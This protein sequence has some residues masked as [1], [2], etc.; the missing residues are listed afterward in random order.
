MSVKIVSIENPF[1]PE[2]RKISD[3]DFIPHRPLSHY[4]IF[5]DP[6]EFDYVIAVNGQIID[7][8]YLTFPKDGDI[9]SVCARL[10]D[11]ISATVATW[12][13]SFIAEGLLNTIVYGAVYGAVFLG[14]SFAIGY[15]MNQLINALG[16]IDEPDTSGVT[17]SPTYGWDILRPTMTEGNPIPIIFG[18]NKVAGQVINKFVT[19]STSEADEKQAAIEYL[20]ILLAICDATTRDA[21]GDL[22]WGIDSDGITDI[23]INDQPVTN[24]KDITT[25]T[26]AGTT[27]DALIPEFTEIVTHQSFDILIPFEETLPSDW[28]ATIQTDGTAVEKLQIILDAKR[29]LYHVKES[30]DPG[31]IKD[32]THTIQ[33]QYKAVGDSGWTDFG[34][35]QITGQGPTPIKKV[36]TIDS[37]SADQ[38][39][40]RMRITACSRVYNETKNTSDVWIV[41]LK[42]I[43][44]DAL[45]YPGVAKYAIK[46]LA[47][48]QLSGVMPSVSCLASRSIVRV[49]NDDT[50]TWVA[51]DA[52]NPAWAAYGLLNTHHGISADQIVWSEFEDWADYC[53]DLVGPDSPGEKRHQAN[54]VLD[55]DE[56]VWN[57]VQNIAR[58]GRGVIVQRGSKY[59]VFV[60]KE[61]SPT[62]LFTM[63][64]I[65]EGSFLLTYLPQED[66][67][68]AVEIT[69]QDPERDY[70]NQVVAVYSS[71]YVDSANPAKKSSVKF[72]AAIR[73]SQVIRE[74]S[75]MLNNNQL[76]KKAI[77]FEAFVDSF[78]CQLGDVVY[79][80]HEIPH[81]DTAGGRV[82]SAENDGGDGKIVLDQAV[83]LTGGT[84][85]KV[86]VRLSD[87][88]LVEKTID[89][90]ESGVG[91]PITELVLTTTWASVPEQYDLYQFGPTDTY[92]K[93]WRITNITRGQELTRRITCLEYNA[94]IYTDTGYTV[95]EPPW[96]ESSSADQEAT[97]VW[98]EENLVYSLGGSYASVI[99]CAWQNVGRTDSPWVVWL[100]DTSLYSD[101]GKEF[102]ATDFRSHKKLPIINRIGFT[103]SNYYRIPSDFLIL[104]HTYTVVISP[105]HY[106]TSHPTFTDANYARIRILGK[107]RPPDDVTGFSASWDSYAGRVSLS[108][109]AVTDIDLAYYEIRLG[110]PWDDAVV[111][112]TAERGS[113]E[114]IDYVAVSQDTTLTYMIKA[115]DSSYVY[116]TTAA[117][118]D[119]E[120]VTTIPVPSGLA[121]ST[122]AE[123]EVDGRTM[124]TITATWD[125]NA[126]ASDIFDHYVILWTN[127]STG[128]VNKVSLGDEN[129]YTFLVSAGILYNV[130]V[131]SVMHSGQSSAF[132]DVESI[133][134]GEDTDAPSDPTAPGSGSLFE[135]PSKIILKWNH[136]GATEKDTSH[137]DIYRYTSNTFSSAS[138]IGSAVKDFT[139]DT[140]MFV[141][142]PGDYDTYYYWVVAV[143]YSGNESGELSLGS[144]ARAKINGADDI[145]AASI[146][147]DSM[148]ADSIT[149]TQIDVATLDAISVDAGTITAG[150]LQNADSPPSAQFDLDNGTF[151]LGPAG[152]PKLNW[153]GTTLEIE[154]NV[155][156]GNPT[157]GIGSYSAGAFPYEDGT[158]ISFNFR[159]SNSSGTAYWFKVAE[160]D[161]GNRT[162]SAFTFNGLI[163]YGSTGGRLTDQMRC[164]MQ[165]ICDGTPAISIATYQ[166]SGDD[167]T[168]EVKLSRDGLVASVYVRLTSWKQVVFDGIWTVRCDTDD[169]W[170]DN[171]QSSGDNIGTSSPVVTEIVAD[172][173]YE[174]G[175]DITGDHSSDVNALVTINGPDEADADVTG[176]NSAGYLNGSINESAYA[177]YVRG[178][179]RYEAQYV[180]YAEFYDSTPTLKGEIYASG[181]YFVL[182]GSSDIQIKVGA[183]GSVQIGGSSAYATFSNSGI[184]MWVNLSLSTHAITSVS[185][186][187]ASGK[188]SG[189]ELEGTSLDINGSGDVSGTLASAAH[190]NLGSSAGYWGKVYTGQYY[191]QFGATAYGGVNGTF[192]DNGGNTVRVRGGIITDLSE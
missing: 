148:A 126:E 186:I 89:N 41:A 149:A 68:N 145:V 30:G 156:V 24:Y 1:H 142:D 188:I 117:T 21:S 57:Q 136:S 138:K 45:I 9:I 132:C 135:L 86:L 160:V 171:N 150:V 113:T 140:G 5:K 32:L 125:A 96:E 12:A 49:Y 75:F 119:V 107:L 80:Q 115:V 16:L 27:T 169:S 147:A 118:D 82:V 141:D 190:G 55:T 79:F 153:D 152:N 25:Y 64:N 174:I 52:T 133:T 70:T 164:R 85:Y 100:L 151:Y 130:Q 23:R 146:T 90:T 2:D 78:A 40:I 38:Y 158:P 134:A 63:G 74:A 168:D 19:I 101:F 111:V 26:R 144:G 92:L 179:C 31:A 99:D 87:N 185:T 139:S 166:Y 39:E 165:I 180:G 102:N 170:F 176:D 53:D 108:W 58:Y 44:D 183:L 28:S 73:R 103:T 129:E 157:G 181:T 81:Y 72:N 120:V 47:T 59:G 124:A 128:N 177:L 189:G 184:T 192:V 155:I 178:T 83:T 131:K 122:S 62:H 67:A 13:S 20:N 18:T 88:T 54:I 191:T 61:A 91:T 29:G 43:I 182:E 94:N 69:Y 162:Q 7:N 84:T 106:G 11:P 163:S 4:S 46:A 36:I 175:A 77:E 76:I 109:N 56:N 110:S 112:Q 6:V 121:L 143:D 3:I 173:N 10:K 14:T 37:L 167:L 71:D 172:S 42:E 60:D 105:S 35:I 34:D 8:P 161:L 123:I 22:A 187:T 93:Q 51:K 50:S 116:S 137:F 65:I 154:G 159:I 97:T 48:D 127:T 66:R 15:G 95:D 17:D 114:A 33:V 104:G 98:L